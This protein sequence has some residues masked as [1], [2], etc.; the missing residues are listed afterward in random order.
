MSHNTA[1]KIEDANPYGAI[2]RA[3]WLRLRA[4]CRDK[5]RTESQGSSG[6]RRKRNR[7]R[8][9]RPPKNKDERTKVYL[10]RLSFLD[11]QLLERAAK[12]AHLTPNEWLRSKM[13][14]AF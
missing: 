1:I 6:T 12:R 4:Y 8:P 2:T 7:H 10:I 11:R 3:E 14:T 13:R 5:D 9:G